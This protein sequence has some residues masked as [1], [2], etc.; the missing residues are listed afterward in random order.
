MDSVFIKQNSGKKIEDGI[1]DILELS[2]WQKDLDVLYWFIM[3]GCY[4]FIERGELN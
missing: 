2:L 3:K 4:F 1:Y